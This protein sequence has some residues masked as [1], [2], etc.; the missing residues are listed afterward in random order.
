[1]LDKGEFWQANNKVVIWFLYN[2][3]LIRKIVGSIQVI[4]KQASKKIGINKE[5][6]VHTLLHS[7]VTHLLKSGVELRYIQEI[8]RHKSS[9]TTEIYTHV[10]N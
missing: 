3:E 9:K 2:Q 10:I 1:M 5:A 8:L 7:F 6:T 4:F